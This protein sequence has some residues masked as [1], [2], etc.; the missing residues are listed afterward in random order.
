MPRGGK[1]P[2][3]GGN[4]EKSKST[5]AKVEQEPIKKGI[6]EPINDNDRHSS[7]TCKEMKLNKRTGKKK[8]P[9]L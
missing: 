7:R 9:R 5:V 1:I 2:K 6:K 4:I 3:F 8:N